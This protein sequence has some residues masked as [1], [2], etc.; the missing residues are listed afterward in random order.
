MLQLMNRK[1]ILI[2]GIILFSFGIGFISF[3]LIM[4]LQNPTEDIPLFIR[5]LGF[6]VMI[7]LHIPFV[8]AG[9]YLIRKGR[10]K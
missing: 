10:K 6:L 2:I 8:I 3:N 9:I 4:S 1:L 7:A 5:V